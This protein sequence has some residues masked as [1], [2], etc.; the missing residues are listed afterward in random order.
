MRFF[1]SWILPSLT[2]A[3]ASNMQKKEWHFSIYFIRHAESIWNQD[4]KAGALTSY[5]RRPV[6]Y[7]GS[8]YYWDAD[9]SQAGNDQAAA[10]ADW[11]KGHMRTNRDAKLI[12]E[13]SAETELIV[14]NLART[15]STLLEALQ[16]RFI[17][18]LVACRSSWL[19][20]LWR[21]I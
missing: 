14:S 10:L 3:A 11:L 7:I 4:K 16:H 12:S 5:I 20:M 19:Q 17:Q 6:N 21:S 15:R 13:R 2:A 8:N 1:S 18:P 9:L